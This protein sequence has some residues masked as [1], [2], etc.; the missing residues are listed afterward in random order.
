[1]DVERPLTPTAIEEKSLAPIPVGVSGVGFAPDDPENPLNFPFLVKARIIGIVCVLTLCLT[2]ASSVYVR[3]L[4]FLL[5]GRLL[6]LSLSE[7]L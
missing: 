3:R 4:Y 6:I 2:Y 7:R 5:V 1:M